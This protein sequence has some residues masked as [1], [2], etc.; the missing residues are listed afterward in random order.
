M[1][2]GGGEGDISWVGAGLGGLLNMDGISG[3]LV[4]P[5]VE[6]VFGVDWD[7]LEGVEGLEEDE[8][9]VEEESSKSEASDSDG[10]MPLLEASMRSLEEA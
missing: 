6:G 10:F 8:F 1:G 4:V 5:E 2:E 3:C 7:G 9:L